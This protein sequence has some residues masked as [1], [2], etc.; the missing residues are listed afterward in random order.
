MRT[1]LAGSRMDGLEI[2]GHPL[3]SGSQPAVDRGAHQAGGAWRRNGRPLV[4]E[5]SRNFQNQSPS[6]FV[7]VPFRGQAPTGAATICEVAQ[8]RPL[9]GSQASA[10]SWC[11]SGSGGVNL[12]AGLVRLT[13]F[14]EMSLERG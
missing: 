8:S 11:S 1:N 7:Q 14:V 6:K 5:S 3:W 9:H 10:S 12:E 13:R 2:D 4:R